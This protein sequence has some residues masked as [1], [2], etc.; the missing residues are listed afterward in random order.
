MKLR[1]SGVGDDEN[2]SRVNLECWVRFG[3]FRNGVERD[4]TKAVFCIL[5]S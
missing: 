3:G 4:R 1:P 2:E 5:W